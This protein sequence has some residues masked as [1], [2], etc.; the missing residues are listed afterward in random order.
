M[1]NSQPKTQIV[2]EQSQDESPL[3]SR[4]MSDLTGQ[5]KRL[6]DLQRMNVLPYLGLATHEAR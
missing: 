4:H 6:Y 1:G 5:G 2:Q 3:W